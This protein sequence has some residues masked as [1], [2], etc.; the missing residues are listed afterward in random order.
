MKLYIC[1]GTYREPFKEHSC[2]TAH[3]ALLAA[4]YEPELVK[5]R[6]LGVGPKLL[7]WTTAGRR[8]VEELSGQKVVPVLL[9]D[10]GEA[11]VESK[12][13]VKWAEAHP[14]SVAR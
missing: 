9:T 5:V 12:A 14:R 11:I 6:G 1:W 10:D 8:E 2:R 13:I 3:Q 4:G 7:Q